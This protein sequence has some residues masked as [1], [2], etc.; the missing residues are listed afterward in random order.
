[1]AENPPH[2]ADAALQSVRGPGNRLAAR[3]FVAIIALAPLPFGS[4]FPAAV[5]F[6]C[7]CLS[8][9]AGLCRTAALSE[10]QAMILLAITAILGVYAAAVFL[11]MASVPWLV[12]PD[13]NWGKATKLIGGELC[14]TSAIARYQPFYSFGP[15]L[16]NILSLSLG[17]VLGADR[18]RARQILL[19]FA[20]SGLAYAIFGIVSALLEPGMILWRERPAY[21]G[22]VVATFVNRNT[23]A[24]YFGSCGA[25]WLLIFCENIKRHLG[26]NPLI[27]KNFLQCILYRARADT[28]VSFT[29]VFICFM[30]LVM[31]NSRAGVIISLSGLVSAGAIYFRHD[32]PKRSSKIRFIAGALCAI[33]IALQL[34]GGSIN[35]HFDISALSDEGRLQ[36][37]Q[38]ALKI[39]V[40]HPWL[41][42]GLGSFALAFPEYRSA[43]ASI[44]GIWDMAHSTPLQIAAEMGLPIAFLVAAAWAGALVILIRGVGIRRRD[45]ILPLSGAMVAL[46]G[47]AHSSVD[48]S[49]QI[50]GYSIVAMGIVGMGLA[51]SFRSAPG[52]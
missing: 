31:T 51:Q 47:L 33:V 37:Y 39:I 45:A 50:P 43:Q 44:F 52:G 34:V 49:L 46:I 38:S 15:V 26:S 24:T 20:W 9:A 7:L 2:G 19:A 23:A 48:F 4:D 10:A 8:L 42:S 25:V 11:Q 21:F 35:R 13:P 6:W 3:L 5:A 29:G 1:V 16:A 41:G 28:I 18:H 14:P 36:T 40:H 32:L 27:W 12:A 30:A 17:I 22:K